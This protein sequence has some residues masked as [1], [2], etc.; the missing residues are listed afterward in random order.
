MAGFIVCRIF[1]FEYFENG[2]NR[3]M[4]ATM[5]EPLAMSAK[6]RDQIL[7]LDRMLHAGAPA[8]LGA[9]GE[10]M[11]VPPTVC[12]ILRRAVEMLA[13]GKSVTLVPEQ[14]ILTTQRAADLLGMSRPHLVKLLEAGMMPY[15][16]VG[17]QRRVKKRDVLAFGARRE[18][19]RQAALDELTRQAFEAGLY[20]RNVLP[21]GKR[22][23]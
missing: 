23:K 15:H 19:D 17:N 4:G 12:T 22:T 2:Y 10:R 20:D 16:R 11:A 8:L 21:A 3:V 7:A 18:E 1:R 9:A 13:E 5:P 14:Q 6:E